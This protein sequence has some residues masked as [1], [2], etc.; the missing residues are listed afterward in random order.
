VSLRLL[1]LL[2]LAM[3]VY[4]WARIAYSNLMVE[5]VQREPGVAP[6]V[7]KERLVECSICGVHV[8]AS[9]ALTKA[10]PGT[11]VLCSETC[12]QRARAAS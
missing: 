9:R 10:R 11:P 1:L 4:R 5:S 2:F 3:L 7:K 12:R 6:S 8:V